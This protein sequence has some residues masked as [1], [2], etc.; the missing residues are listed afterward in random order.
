[1]CDALKNDLLH[2]RRNFSHC[3]SS[4]ALCTNLLCSLLYRESSS[5]YYVFIQ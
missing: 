4:L 2:K 3:C 5:D 1:M